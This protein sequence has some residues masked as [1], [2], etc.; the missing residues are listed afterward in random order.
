MSEDQLIFLISQPRS[1]SSLLQQLMLNSEVISSTPETWQMLSLIHTYK[2][3]D[4]EDSYNPNYTAI[5]FLDYLNSIDNGLEEFK[6]KI[7]ELSLYFYNKKCSDSTFFLDKTPRY[8]HIINEL[9]ELFPNAKF[10]FL[11]RNPLAVFSSILDYNFKGDY[12]KF[13]ASSDRVDDLFLAP[14]TINESIKK[15]SNHILVKYE[16]LVS[17]SKA[18]LTKL[19]AYLNIDLPQDLESYIVNSVFSNTNSIDTKSL[20]KHSGPEL[21]YLNS[22]KKTIDTSQKKK[23]ALGYINKLANQ[24][25]DYFSYNLKEIE[26]L[27]IQHKSVKNSIFNLKLDYFLKR[28]NQLKFSQILK[29]RVYLKLQQK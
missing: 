21:N 20:K 25:E 9:Y 10:I 8:Y 4:I 24:H 11:V 27:L 22:W 2:K 28:D 17:N 5:N 16:N 3:N 12:I 23:L 15:N 13:L 7:K 19:F 6:N 18:E 29:K 26:T 14:K 1:G